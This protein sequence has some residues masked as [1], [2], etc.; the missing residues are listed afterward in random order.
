MPPPQC[1][2]GGH[3]LE[4]Q[5]HGR[6]AGSPW[7]HCP[8]KGRPTSRPTGFASA[9][10]HVSR[11]GGHGGCSGNRCEVGCLAAAE[12]NEAAPD[13]LNVLVRFRRSSSPARLSER[14]AWR[15]YK[16]VHRVPA[17]P[18]VRLQAG[19]EG[20]PRSASHFHPHG[21]RPIPRRRRSCDFRCVSAPIV[22]F[23]R[24]SLERRL[25]TDAG[26]SSVGAQ[27]PGM[28]RNPK[29]GNRAANRTR[30]DEITHE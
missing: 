2:A 14:L 15:R 10:K 8:A 19:G 13:N 1:D 9:A 17:R 28:I 30:I 3:S 26:G 20:T 18:K 16:R 5:Q 29:C 6:R 25:D 22:P 11:L 23:W 21:K 4:E 12:P 24:P 27:P 7:T